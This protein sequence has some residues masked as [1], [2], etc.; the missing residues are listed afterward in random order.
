[1]RRLTILVAGLMLVIGGAVPALAGHGDPVDGVWR[2]TDSD[3]S[4]MMVS[5]KEHANDTGYFTV[6]LTDSRATGACTPAARMEAIT[7]GALYDDGSKVLFADFSD[8]ECAGIATPTSL[9]G[10]H[11]EWTVLEDD[12]I[13]VDP[14]GNVWTHVRG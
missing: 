12:L 13:M 5:I 6:V 10:F 4:K 7:S 9:D 2:A 3:G 8:I 1:M 11:Y 14:W